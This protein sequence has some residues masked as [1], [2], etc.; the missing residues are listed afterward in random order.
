VRRVANQVNDLHNK[1]AVY[2]RPI[3]RWATT[4]IAITAVEGL[5]LQIPVVYHRPHYRYN[6]IAE[7]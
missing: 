7:D 5:Q 3:V 2:H 6:I 1:I 4:A